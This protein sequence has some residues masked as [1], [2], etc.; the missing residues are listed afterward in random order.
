MGDG[1]GE[2]M[3][4]WFMMG[5]GWG[6]SLMMGGGDVGVVYEDSGWGVVYDRS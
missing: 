1:W 2:G 6:L 5:D 4:V 3:W